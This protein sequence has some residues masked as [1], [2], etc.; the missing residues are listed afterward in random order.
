MTDT[1]HMRNTENTKYAKE[2]VKE[3]ELI[4]DTKEFEDFLKH[5]ER[6]MYRESFGDSV[7]RLCVK[8][9]ITAALLQ[10]RIAM[11]KSQFYNVLNGNRHPSKESV[12]K[13]A[14][15]LKVTQTELNELLYAAG[16]CGLDPRRKED[17]IILF[18]LAHQKEV[19]KIDELLREYNSKIRLVDKE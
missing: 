18:G 11:S 8:Y 9:K 7:L 3:L 5:H 2:I 12:I 16:Y 15:G 17:A 14:L 1:K 13:I 19:G 4:K 10:P 6:E